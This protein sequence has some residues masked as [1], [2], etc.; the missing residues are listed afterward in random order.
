MLTKDKT[1]SGQELFI[2]DQKSIDPTI[3]IKDKNNDGHFDYL[4]ISTENSYAVDHNL[5]GWIDYYSSKKQTTVFFEGAYRKLRSEGRGKKSR[6]YVFMSGK[7]LEI[8]NPLII[9]PFK[10]KQK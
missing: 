6:Y 1:N 10:R 4:G 2:M 8:E 5:D 9:F 3:Q 7:W